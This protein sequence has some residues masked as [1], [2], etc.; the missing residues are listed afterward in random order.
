MIVKLNLK[1]DVESTVHHGHS[2]IVFRTGQI[3]RLGNN[4]SIDFE[5]GAQNIRYLEHVL[6]HT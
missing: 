2:D 4:W 1:R 3:N 5:D 6:H